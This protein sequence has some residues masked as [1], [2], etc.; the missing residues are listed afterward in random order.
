MGLDQLPTAVEL[1]Q[2]GVGAGVQV[3]ADQL[4]R[5]RVERLGDLDMPV[6]GDLRVR[7]HR[8]VIQPVRGRQQQVLL[9]GGEVL[10]RPPR[11][12]AMHPQPGRRRA[13]VLDAALRVGQV[14]ERLA[15]EEVAAHVLH[16]SLDP[17]LVPHR[18]LLLMR[19]VEVEPFG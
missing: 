2:P 17:R 5:H 18:Q 8:H 10:G 14:E 13:P 1:H 9:V 7:E 6:P 11:G 19:M 15:G 12:G 4:A 16:H 3:P